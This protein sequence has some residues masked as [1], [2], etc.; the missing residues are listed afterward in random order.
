[1]CPECLGALVVDQPRS[2]ARSHRI[3]VS[4]GALSALTMLTLGLSFLREVIIAAKI[5]AGPD[6]DAYLIA[7]LYPT[8][9]ASIFAST[10]GSTFVP[11][12]QR[13][14]LDGEPAQSD[15]TNAAWTVSVIVIL[16]TALLLGACLHPL[17]EV[18]T[19]GFGAHG[20]ALA[21]EMAALLLPTGACNGLVA[22][23]SVVLNARKSFVMPALA[24]PLNAIA[25]SLAVL[26]F[27]NRFG[28]FTIVYGSFAGAVVGLVVVGIAARRDGV[29]LRLVKTFWTPSVSRTVRLAAPLLVGVVAT[30][31]TVFVDR[32]MAST[33]GP[34]SIA[35]LGYAD[36]V[37]KIPEAVIMGAL[38]VVLF[39]YLSESALAGESGDLRTVSTFG[40]ALM[41]TVLVPVTV[42]CVSLSGPLVE[43]LF[44]RGRFDH[45]AAQLT[46]SALSGYALGLT[47]NGVGYV[48]PRVLL[49][50]EKNYTIALLGCGNVILKVIYNALLMPRFGQA[51]I[52]FGTSLMYATTDVFFLVALLYYGV[53]LNVKVMARGLVVGASLGTLMFLVVLAAKVMAPSAL[54]QILSVG[55]AT[56]GLAYVV[57]RSRRLR[58]L[59]LPSI[60]AS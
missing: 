30:F 25:V 24:V 13:A 35:S 14:A 48:F 3:L 57:Y 8:F 22:F 60:S 55:A 37:V 5:G 7:A 47:F 33:L 59:L 15:F 4:A 11:V 52:A 39:P 21:T 43:L 34:G 29:K 27:G 44:Q 58:T 1:M 38:P 20:R 10:L 36:K 19:P 49:A 41:V 26:L 32:A 50:L 16:V 40:L 23:Q 2:D 56:G 53:G 12:Y 46:A 6:I 18:A 42:F 17:L 51:G 45:T 9:L 54:A 31:A 28:V